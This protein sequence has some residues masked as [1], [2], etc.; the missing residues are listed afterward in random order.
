MVVVVV[1]TGGKRIKDHALRFQASFTLFIVILTF[2]FGKDFKI[3]D[4]KRS[5][6]VIVML[7]IVGATPSI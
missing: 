6:L 3:I 5:K 7:S 1:S 2:T 4:K